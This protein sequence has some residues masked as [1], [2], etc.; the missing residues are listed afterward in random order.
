MDLEG[1]EG[2]DGFTLARIEATRRAVIS[3][4]TPPPAPT[5]CGLQEAAPLH[6]HA[7]P[8]LRPSH[9]RHQRLAMIQRAPHEH[10]D[11]PHSAEA[12]ELPRQPM[13]TASL[14]PTAIYR[15]TATIPLYARPESSE[16]SSAPRRGFMSNSA[17]QLPSRRGSRCCHARCHGCRAPQM[18]QPERGS[19]AQ[20]AVAVVAVEDVQMPAT[21]FVAPSASSVR[22]AD[23]CPTGPGGRPVSKRPVSTRTVRSPG[24]RTDR[25]PVSAACASALST[26]RLLVVRDS[27]PSP[28]PRPVGRL[29][30]CSR[31]SAARRS[32]AAWKWV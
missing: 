17:A 8:R 18:L 6:H 28:V 25:R 32:A 22:C 30:V 1:L 13:P 3:P 19:A 16:D 9:P 21:P 24:V 23:V 4:V 31:S 26:P 5:P 2:L 12:T 27:H 10:S 7:P 14:R 11:D 29:S 15:M 20:P